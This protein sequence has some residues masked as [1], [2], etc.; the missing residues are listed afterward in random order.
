MSEARADR[1]RK[2]RLGLWVLGWLVLIEVVEF[3]VGVNLQHA[4]IPLVVLAIPPAW[5]ILRYFMHIDRLRGGG[6]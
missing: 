5:L 4:L 3:V 6:E 1:G 2:M